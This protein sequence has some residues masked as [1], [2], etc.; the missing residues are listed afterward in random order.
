MRQMDASSSRVISD[1]LQLVLNRHH[2]L[3]GQ[4]LSQPEASYKYT[5]IDDADDADDDD[6]G[7][8]DDDDDDDD[9]RWWW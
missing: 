4:R 6:D 3:C 7:S 8:G 9:C 1:T 5:C 2:R